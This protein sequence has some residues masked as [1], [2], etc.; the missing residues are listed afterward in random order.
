V[1]KSDLPPTSHPGDGRHPGS[2]ESTRS[3]RIGR[4][5]MILDRRAAMVLSKIQAHASMTTGARDASSW[6]SN[7]FSFERHGVSSDSVRSAG[8]WFLERELLLARGRARR[9][10]PRSFRQR[11]EQRKACP[12]LGWSTR[13]R[14]EGLGGC[15]HSSY[16]VAEV[17][18][19]RRRPKTLHACFTQ[20]VNGG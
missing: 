2:P 8:A 17:D 15:V 12:G 19:R 16:R 20:V 9:S 14:F 11:G 6:G 18:R 10:Q 13:A 1:E 5:R 4:F 3:S 7:T